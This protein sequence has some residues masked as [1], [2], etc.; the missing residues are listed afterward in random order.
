MISSYGDRSQ[1]TRIISAYLFIIC[2]AAANALPPN[3]SSY[4]GEHTLNFYTCQSN[5][6][7]YAHRNGAIKLYYTCRQIHRRDVISKLF[8]YSFAASLCSMLAL[9]PAVENGS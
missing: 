1:T 5:I 8:F 3:C 7:R 4:S 6:K 2:V 9:H